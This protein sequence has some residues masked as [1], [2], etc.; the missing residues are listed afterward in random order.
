MP[1]SQSG[2]TRTAPSSTP[3]SFGASPLSSASLSSSSSPSDHV[4]SSS[5]GHA[6]ATM[7]PGAVRSSSLLHAHPMGQP[8]SKP[9]PDQ[10]NSPTSGAS[11]SSKLKRAL[12]GRRKKSEDINVD[13][14]QMKGPRQLTL[15]VS[16]ALGVGKKSNMSPIPPSPPPKPPSLQGPSKPFPPPPPIPP[17]IIPAGR[18]SIMPITPGVSS[19]VNFMIGQE[20][21]LD[22]MRHEKD[23]GPEEAC[24]ES[25][26]TWRRSDATITHHSSAAGTRPSRPVSVAESLQSNHTIVAPNKR[27]SALVMDTDFGMVEEDVDELRPAEPEQVVL[28]RT[29]PRSAS[30]N[31]GPSQPFV[32]ADPATTVSPKLSSETAPLLT[33]SI[34]RE[35]PTLTRTAANGFIAP[36]SSGLQSTGHNIR[37]RLAAWTATNTAQREVPSASR[38]SALA[39]T[40]AR[41]PTLSI[42]GGFAPAAGL[43]K[44]AVEK[45][46]RA[47]GGLT[48]G[49]SS[50]YS[51]SSSSAPSSYT[52]HE[53]S[54]ARTI[55]NQS[56][57]G[58]VPGKAPKHRRTPNS[59]SSAWSINS[60]SHS[61][62]VSDMDAFAVPD[63]PILGTCLRRPA[64]VTG[65]TAG[66]VF[67][68]QLKFAVRMAP[69]ASAS[70]LAERADIDSVLVKELESRALPALVVRC[71]QHILIWG[72]QE[73][74]LFRVTGRPSHTSKLRSE[75][76][77][78]ADFDMTSCT[79][80][81]LDPHS[82]SSV[83]KAFLRELP[84]SILT[85]GLIPYFDVA[86]AQENALQESQNSS[87][88]KSAAGPSL[89]SGPRSGL[90]L[91]KPPS[92][93]TLAMP[94]MAL[95]RPPSQSLIK[96]LRSL[97][98][99]LPTENRDLLRTVTDLIRAT[100]KRSR[101]TKMPLSNLLL[102]FCPSLNMNP[103]LLRALCEAESVWT[104][105]T[106][107]VVDI[108]SEPAVDVP[109]QTDSPRPRSP[110]ARSKRA[111]HAAFHLDPDDDPPA[112]DV[113]SVSTDDRSSEPRMYAP[114]PM[115]SSSVESLQT[116]SSG[117][118]L[119]HL[120]LERKS[121][122]AQPDMQPTALIIADPPDP[123]FNVSSAHNTPVQFP[124]MP[125]PGTPSSS[126]RLSAAFSLPSLTLGN[127]SKPDLHSADSAPASPL[128][129]LKKP[130]LQLLFSKRSAS[131]LTSS[132][133][134]GHPLISAPY[135]QS[136]RAASESS[137]STPVTALESPSP[138]EPPVLDT[139]IES[140]SLRAALGIQIDSPEDPPAVEL[141][142]EQPEPDLLQP[143]IGQTPIA[144]HYKH[145]LRSTPARKISQ[146][147]ISSSTSSNRLGVLEP[148]V[149]EENW[150]QSVLLAADIDWRDHSN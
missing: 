100:A 50:G 106:D 25:K 76:D 82:V 28:T 128:R 124:T 135:L 13:S 23:R 79:P 49:S 104:E 87:R 125:S 117:P 32:A 10:L 149:A 74:G 70:Q 62:S 80:G 99:Q 150:T 137:L 3:A 65:K 12:A 22:A 122:E 52:S 90:A 40:H 56:G 142:Q 108:C 38:A 83:F 95:M 31:V 24:D 15:Q 68:V 129:R 57:S 14:I 107:C 47:W 119:E 17:S 34:S 131:P 30:L 84:E 73:E 94:N 132:S 71:A 75:F 110:G 148:D 7:H 133:H 16:Q 59:A 66:I 102:V 27:L 21:A 55:S 145:A 105:E 115:F 138:S 64:H 139:A 126:K 60:S 146:T 97:I 147:S 109:A 53:H 123:L 41:Q 20:R 33:P 116:P 98:A 78:G 6:S 143:V 35:T 120:P 141:E 130:S 18:G 114:S 26:E 37:G 144:D 77:C 113:S 8:H 5:S 11:A 89:P 81:D 91:R 118:S 4:G 112:D 92:L 1:S 36:S 51:S 69:I 44:R 134:G 43:A 2:R 29:K 111:Q 61:S 86:L 42:S 88:V 127:F 93:S 85:K 19:A 63:G 48:A 46:G 58:A 140:S 136:P 54:L 96:A 121:F 39:Q 101:E 45:M 9:S 72:V 67:G 103:P